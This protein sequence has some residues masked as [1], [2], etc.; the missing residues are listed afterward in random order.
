MHGYVKMK[1][2]ILGIQLL[3]HSRLAFW[4]YIRL[5]SLDGYFHR[6]DITFPEKKGQNGLSWT[7][8]NDPLCRLFMPC[9]H[10][11]KIVLIKRNVWGLPAEPGLNA[12][13][14]QNTAEEQIHFLSLVLF[15]YVEVIH[16]LC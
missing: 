13:T 3:L 2:C 8:R 11:M 16:K 9:T 5:E 15:N 1:V 12:A 4:I 10:K 6:L 14:T 7:H